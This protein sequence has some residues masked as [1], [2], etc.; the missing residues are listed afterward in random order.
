[1]GCTENPQVRRISEEGVWGTLW[2]YPSQGFQKGFAPPLANANNLRSTSDFANLETLVQ[3]SI[4]TN[5]NT[6][7][8]AI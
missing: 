4:V 7:F 3:N 1:M 5:N 2:T 6:E 8:G